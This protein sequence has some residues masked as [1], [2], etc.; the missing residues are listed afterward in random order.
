MRRKTE[1]VLDRLETPTSNLIASRFSSLTSVPCQVPALMRL[2]ALLLIISL[3]AALAEETS[4]RAV[5]RTGGLIGGTPCSTLLDFTARA[6]EVGGIKTTAGMLEVG[7]HLQ[8]IAGFR[9]G[10]NLG[11][12]RANT[13]MNVFG[14]LRNEDVLLSVENWCAS[15]PGRTFD[16]GIFNFYM[17]QQR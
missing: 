4:G 8:Y 9:T 15:N 2:A 13:E 17:S 11:T 1:R 14:D 7:H 16:D 3:S 6:R 12:A 10:F 5:F